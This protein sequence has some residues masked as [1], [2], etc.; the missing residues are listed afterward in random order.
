MNE[1]ILLFSLKACIYK[2][3]IYGIFDIPNK[4]TALNEKLIMQLTAKCSVM[5]MYQNIL[6]INLTTFNL[7]EI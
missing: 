5:K 2:T 6:F 4:N 3:D 1:A 7:N